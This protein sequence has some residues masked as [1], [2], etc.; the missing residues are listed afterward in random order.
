MPRKILMSKNDLLR[1]HKHLIK[2]LKYG[3]RPAQIKEANAQAKEA[4]KYK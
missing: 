3:S 2:V 1:E 4:K